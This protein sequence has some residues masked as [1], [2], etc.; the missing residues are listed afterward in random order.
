MKQGQKAEKFILLPCWIFVISRIRS[1]N[2]NFRNTKAEMFSEVT[3]KNNSGSYAVFTEHGSSPS[4]MTAAKVMVV[5]AGCGG[6]AADAVS[7]YTQVKKQDAPSLLK[8][9]IGMSK[10][11]D[12]STK[13]QIAEIM[14]QHGRPSR[15]S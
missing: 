11:L 15:S 12:M 14:V 8:K 5:I 2:P 3:L 10:Y 1:W 4:Q 9:K 13:T 6:Q 7:A